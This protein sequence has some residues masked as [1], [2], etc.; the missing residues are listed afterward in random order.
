MR[1][2]AWILAIVLLGSYAYFYQAGGW[3]QNSRLDLMRSLAEHGSVRIDGYDQNTGD[4]AT[5]EGNVYSDK[6]PGQALLGTPAVAATSW[7]AGHVGA[8]PATVV[9][10]E[11][12]VATLWAAGVP[13][14]VAA[15]CLAIAAR[16]LGATPMAAAFAAL[17]YGLGS[18]AWAY[19]TLLWGNAL[20]AGCL[21]LAFTAAVAL[22][23]ERSCARDRLL[24]LLVGAT[25]GWSVVAEYEAAPAAVILAGL[26][27]VHA[28]HAG[29]HR[30]RRI[31]LWLGIGALAP[32]LILAA[33]N[34]AA[35]GSPL[36]IGYESVTDFPGMQEGL[37]GVTLPARRALA[38]I[39]FGSFR[40]LLPLA[41]ALILA[42]IGLALLWQR[43]RAAR[44]SLVAA[45]GV[46]VYYLLL[47]ASYAYWDGG[48]SYG[49]RLVG[50][51]LPFMCLGV[52][53]AVSAA[54][55]LAWVLLALATC[56]VVVTCMAVATTVMPANDVKAPISQLIWPAF[57]QG[58][59]ALNRWTFG[60]PQGEAGTG[61]LKS[62]NVG[63]LLGLSGL[64][65]LLPLLAIWALAAAVWVLTARR[66]RE[67]EWK[68]SPGQ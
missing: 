41:P 28:S 38:E 24:A 20:A 31:S 36:H 43:S 53:G 64:P 19:A 6:A 2:Q 29:W 22:R 54:R 45:A 4:K 56:G 9:A 44:P 49:P 13:T 18:P 3:N 30:V 46:T 52:A 48:A 12:Y 40:G 21:M 37:L 42:P 7:L 26:A 62:W 50:A 68:M 66:A 65:S 16:Q 60:L 17:T 33:Y 67:T 14:V 23:T 39:L 8:G 5:F 51:A 58:N 27:V 59:L 57:S 32:L 35:F 10:A 15:L 25:A 55:G 61:L 63:Q 34:V 1:L 11:S 47:N